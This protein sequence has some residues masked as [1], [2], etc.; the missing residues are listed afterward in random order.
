MGGGLAGCRTWKRFITHELPSQ[1]LAD[2]NERTILC[3]RKC[4]MSLQF[5]YSL[6]KDVTG[7]A[8]GGS[9]FA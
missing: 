8:G 4:R 6:L 5:G 3:A 9:H 2:A 1:G 7:C